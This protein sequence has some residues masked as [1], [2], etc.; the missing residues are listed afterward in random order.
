MRNPDRIVPIIRQ[1]ERLWMEYPDLR[2][3][4]LIA[5]ITGPGDSFYLEDDKF[6][7]LLQQFRKQH[8][9]VQEEWVCGTLDVKEKER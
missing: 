1:L 3:C 5:G 2:L 9:S 6:F 4:Q 8:T 7:E